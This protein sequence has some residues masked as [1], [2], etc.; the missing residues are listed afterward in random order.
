MTLFLDLE[1][2]GLNKSGDDEPVEIAIID[3]SGE[4]VFCSLVRPVNRASWPR[5]EEIHGIGP[6]HVKDM[7][8]WA[9]IEPIALEIMQR[10]LVVI[11]N[12]PFDLSFFNLSDCRIRYACAMRRLSDLRE[13]DGLGDRWLTL[14]D[15]AALA[16]HDLAY[17]H[18]AKADAL[19]CRAL[20]VWL[21]E[22]ERKISEKEE[23]RASRAAA[24][25]VKNAAGLATLASNVVLSESRKLRPDE[26]PENAF[27]AS[28]ILKARR[29][30][31]Q[32]IIAGQARCW[33][34]YYDVYVPAG[35]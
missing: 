18:D 20:W 11:Y 9:T 21:D 25:S 33:R 32:W 26:I 8:T 27:S 24:R 34:G 35:R 4:D 19:A 2:T 31:E 16:G 6:G 3:D 15:A 22:Y 1:T 30:H 5:A 23:K 14:S 29:E 28:Q 7:P 12:A 17:A 13:R 10:D